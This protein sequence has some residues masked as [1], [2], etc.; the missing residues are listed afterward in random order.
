[1]PTDWSTIRLVSNVRARKL[2]KK[3]QQVWWSTDFCC[4]VWRMH[5]PA[6]Q[7]GAPK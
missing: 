1:M 7:H 3:R 4:Y 6:V 5:R 2:R